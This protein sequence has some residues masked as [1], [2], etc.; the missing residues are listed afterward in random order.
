MVCRY[1]CWRYCS[2]CPHTLPPHV[3][4]LKAQLVHS[5]LVLQGLEVD[6]SS[7][8]SLARSLQALRTAVQDPAIMDVVQL[9]ATKPMQVCYTC[10]MCCATLTAMKCSC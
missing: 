5:T 2:V 10:Y 8:G 1:F 6:V 9:L 3:S 7:A 4:S